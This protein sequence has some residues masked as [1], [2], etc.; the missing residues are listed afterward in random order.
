MT[1]IVVDAS[2][3]VK[4]LLPEV[5]AKAARR[6]LRGRREL[7]AP[8]LMWAEVG[9]AVWKKCRRAELT[10]EEA[11]DIL[12]D[13][14]RFPVQTYTAKALLNPAWDLA[15]RLQL[16]IYDSLYLALAI[17]RGATLVTADRSLYR[18]VKRQPFGSAIVWVEH[19]R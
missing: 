15:E 10:S 12:Q 11:R 14:R 5:Y 13:F 1:E 17:S 3:A 8:D 7:V 4:W 18:T 19:I 6:L 16:T 2:V 9:N